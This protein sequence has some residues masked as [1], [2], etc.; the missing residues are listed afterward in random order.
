MKL[1]V[2]AFAN[3][4]SIVVAAVY[5]ICATAVALFPEFMVTLAQSWFHGI[6]LTPLAGWQRTPAEFVW[7]L[8]ST[9]GLTWIASYLFATL[10]NRLAKS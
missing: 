6:A 2:L 9:T 5:L 4:L 3:S 7:G 10:Y 1:D 8:L